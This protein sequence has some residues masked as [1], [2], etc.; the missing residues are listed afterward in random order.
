MFFESLRPNVINI[1]TFDLWLKQ[2]DVGSLKKKACCIDNLWI[3]K[4][5]AVSFYQIN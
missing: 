5:G 3:V 4:K 2:K 1:P